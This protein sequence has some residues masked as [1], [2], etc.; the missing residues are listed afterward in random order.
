MSFPGTIVSQNHLGT[1]EPSP[2]P[3]GPGRSHVSSQHIPCG[4]V[5]LLLHN[6]HCLAAGI[7][8][9]THELHR[10]KKPP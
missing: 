7:N 4:P 1:V 8:M 9:D 5:G 10:Y 6:T 3:G 2:V